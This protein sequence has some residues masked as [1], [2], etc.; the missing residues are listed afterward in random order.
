MKQTYKYPDKVINF[1]KAHAHEYGLKEMVAVLNSEYQGEYTFTY[2]KVSNIYTSHNIHGKKRESIFSSEIKAFINEHFVGIGPTKMTSLI[3]ELFGTAYTRSQIASYY[4]THHLKCGVPDGQFTKGQIPHNKGKKWDDFISKDG[5]LRI[6]RTLA[7][8]TKAIHDDDLPVGSLVLKKNYYYR[9]ISIR[10]SRWR[11]AH[12]IEW[13]EHNGP[14]PEDHVL[15][16]ADGNTSNWHI[17]NLMLISKTH[18]FLRNI[19]GIRGYDLQS[20]ETANLIVQLKHTQ[21]QKRKSRNRK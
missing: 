6:K 1:I 2:S 4:S 14:I 16:F 13:E 18:N 9:K 19:Y 8:Y 12:Y 5:Q 3:N 17:D 15:I 7:E 21:K 11:L 10:P 20:N